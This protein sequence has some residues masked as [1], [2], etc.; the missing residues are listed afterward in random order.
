MKLT[1]A[2]LLLLGTSFLLAATLFI[3]GCAD[4][5][6]D[7]EALDD[8]PHTGQ[9]T[10]SK[11]RH[12]HLFAG[13]GKVLDRY[14]ELSATTEFILGVSDPVLDL[15]RVID[16]YDNEPGVTI[17]RTYRKVYRGFAMHVDEAFVPALLNLIELDPDIEWIEPDPK[18][19]KNPGQKFKTTGPP[20][21]YMPWGIDRIG[22]PSSTAQSGNGQGRVEVDIYILDTGIKNKDIHVVEEI[23]FVSGNTRDD[24]GHGTHIAGTAAAEDDDDGVVGVA[25]GARVHNLKVLA[26][27]GNTEF[28]TVIAAVEYVTEQKAANPQTPMVVN[29][30][31]G[32]D[33]GTSQYNAL[34]EAIAS[35]IAQGVVYVIA[36]GNEGIDAS[37]I[38]PAH[39][40]EAIT[41]A[42]YDARSKFAKFSNYGTLID[43]L[44]PGEGV[45]GLEPEELVY[46]KMSGTSMAAPHVTGAVALYL[47]QHPT[48]PPAAVLTALIDAAD[49]GRIKGQVPDGTTRLALDVRSF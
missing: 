17:K 16:R 11:M 34:D 46:S 26:G 7:A 14:A 9:A 5:V 25:P 39:V 23:S 49:D 8:A 37:N 28:S 32:A 15:Y 36:A 30:S 21:Q 20:A 6:T 29:I 4:V 24:I 27:N 33:V 10:P 31:F 19:R 40:A 18:V 48:A 13:A 42:A 41:V 3:T 45:D 47:S 35:S 22:G 44:A 2:I 38:T 1:K 43:L 12:A